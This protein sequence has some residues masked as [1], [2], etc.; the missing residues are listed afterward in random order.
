MNISED[1]EMAHLNKLVSFPREEK[2]PKEQS[3]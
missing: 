2:L 3:A 1:G